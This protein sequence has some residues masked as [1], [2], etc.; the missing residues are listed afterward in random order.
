MEGLIGIGVERTDDRIVVPCELSP[1][2]DYVTRA[3][4]RPF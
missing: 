4:E 2:V 1:I 3:T